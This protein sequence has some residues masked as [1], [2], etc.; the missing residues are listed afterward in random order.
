MATISTALRNFKEP[1]KDQ[2]IQAFFSIP[3]KNEEVNKMEINA[4]LS[5]GEQGVEESYVRLVFCVLDL[6]LRSFTGWEA[7]YHC[8]VSRVRVAGPQVCALHCPAL[9]HPSG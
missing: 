7:V 6:L 3:S 5:L 9:H 4:V 8:A 2:L 1:S